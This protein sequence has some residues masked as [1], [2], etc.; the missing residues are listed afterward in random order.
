MTE[1]YFATVR[2]QR[3]EQYRTWSQTRV[4]FL[5]HTKLRPQQAQSLLGRSAFLVPRGIDGPLRVSK[6]ERRCVH[7]CGYAV[8][9]PWAP[10]ASAVAQVVTARNEDWSRG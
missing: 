4:H 9:R 8:E 5:R 7:E 6:P 1:H 2:A 10:N 3:V